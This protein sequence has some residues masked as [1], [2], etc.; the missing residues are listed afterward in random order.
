MASVN[1]ESKSSY[2]ELVKGV[3]VQFM[4]VFNQSMDSYSLAMNDMVAQQ[5]NKLSSLAKQLNTDKSTEHFIQKTGVNYLGI[6]AENA[7]FN[8]DSRLLGY[9][10]SVAPQ[11][12]TQSVTVSYEAMKDS[13]YKSKLD[14][15]ADLSV[16]GKETMDKV[17]FDMF[18]YAFTAQTSLPVS[19]VGYGDG[20]P[21]AN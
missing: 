1:I 14:E 3:G 5:G 8:S 10:T 4:D 20:K 19:I 17:F 11:K 7:S 13:D 21:L 6:T 15:F 2:G 12:F 9:K 18:N 16:S